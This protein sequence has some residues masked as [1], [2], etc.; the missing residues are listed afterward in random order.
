MK[1]ITKVIDYRIVRTLREFDLGK[2]IK[3][4]IRYGYEP[5]G[6]ISVDCL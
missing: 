6:G 2:E 4:Y 5:I 1:K 3:S